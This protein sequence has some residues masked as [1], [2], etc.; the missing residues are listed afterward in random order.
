MGKRQILTHLIFPT[1]RQTA[2]KRDKRR[3]RKTHSNPCRKGTFSLCGKTHLLYLA[4]TAASKQTRPNFFLSLE[5]RQ[6]NKRGSEIDCSSSSIFILA[7][8]SSFASG[9]SDDVSYFPFLLLLYSPAL[10]PHFRGPSLLSF[11]SLQVILSS[12]ANPLQPRAV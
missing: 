12:S 6:Q 8:A 1:N 7:A 10:N 2:W 4:T 9:H 3:R 5:K 11:S